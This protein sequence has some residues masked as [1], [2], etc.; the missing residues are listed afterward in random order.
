MWT[1][2][3]IIWFSDEPEDCK[4]KKKKYFVQQQKIKNVACRPMYIQWTQPCTLVIRH[5]LMQ[6]Y[7]TS[8]IISIWTWS[9]LFNLPTFMPALLSTLLQF[10]L[11]FCTNF[12]FPMSTDF[13]YQPVETKTS[14]L[15]SYVIFPCQQQTKEFTESNTVYASANGLVAT[16]EISKKC[17]CHL[18]MFIYQWCVWALWMRAVL[19]IFLRYKLPLS[20]G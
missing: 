11:C 2:W 3:N 7:R 12:K 14:H 5:L 10:M 20:S 9:A 19:S 6:F 16:L 17:T 15:T 13:L 18:L 8:K 1:I 4:I